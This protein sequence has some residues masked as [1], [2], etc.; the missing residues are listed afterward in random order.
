[1]LDKWEP[2]GCHNNK[3]MSVGSLVVGGESS[4]KGANFKVEIVKRP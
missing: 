1:M 3:G 4:L 2:E